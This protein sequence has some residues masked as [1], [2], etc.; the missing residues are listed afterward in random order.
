M[1]GV[2]DDEGS[3]EE[4]RSMIQASTSNSDHQSLDDEASGM[5]MKRME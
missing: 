5:R 3:I 4:M 2:Q 1:G